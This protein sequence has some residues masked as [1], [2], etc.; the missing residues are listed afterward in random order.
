MSDAS[1]FTNHEWHLFKSVNERRAE[2]ARR[3]FGAID[4]EPVFCIAPGRSGT[5]YISEIIA[6]ASDIVAF[7]EPLPRFLVLK[8]RSSREAVIGLDFLIEQKA[9]QIAILAA[10]KRLYVETSHVFGKGA[11]ELMFQTG[12]SF[13]P[14]FVLRDLNAVAQS[15]LQIGS[16]P[17][18]TAQGRAFLLDPWAPHNMLWLG[19]DPPDAPRLCAWYAAET[20]LRQLYFFELHAARAGKASLILYADHLTPKM[21]CREFARCSLI[22]EGVPRLRVKEVFSPRDFRNDKPLEKCTSF[23]SAE[24]PFDWDA[25]TLRLEVRPPVALHPDDTRA[26]IARASED[27]AGTWADVI[28]GINASEA[29]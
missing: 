1:K 11:A 13:V 16:V 12:I 4:A 10:G 22:P 26:L 9:P 18:R 6:E 19:E 8:D 2:D 17:A 15:F 29:P 21:I 7:H 24:A 28:A 3:A 20:F 5:R 14:M 25:F 23:T 27:I